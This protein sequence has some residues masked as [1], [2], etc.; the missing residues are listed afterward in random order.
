MDPVKKQTK[1]DGKRWTKDKEDFLIANYQSLSFK[2]LSEAL[3]RSIEGIRSKLKRMNLSKD[4]INKKDNRNNLI[5]KP[6]V[7][8]PSLPAKVYKRKPKVFESKPTVEMLAV[9]IDRKTTIYI[10]SGEDPETAKLNYFKKREEYL[11]SK[12]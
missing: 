3:E 2:E 11:L 7:G 8:K 6:L 4:P 12:K 1:M 5:L 10:K 9:Y